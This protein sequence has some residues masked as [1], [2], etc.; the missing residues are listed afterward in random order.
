M[1]VI[2]LETLA[3]SLL[4]K[5]NSN[6]KDFFLL[7]LVNEPLN[8]HVH[9]HVQSKECLKNILYVSYYSFLIMKWVHKTKE[10]GIIL[11]DIKNPTVQKKHEHGHIV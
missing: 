10:H 3:N 4:K 5:N 2:E 9:L 7:S 1:T 8:V 6:W 11:T